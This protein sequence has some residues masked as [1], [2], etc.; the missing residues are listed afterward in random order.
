MPAHHRQ[1]AGNVPGSAPRPSR[2]PFAFLGRIILFLVGI[3]ILFLAVL[4]P[5]KARL[6]LS[7]AIGRTMN[8]FYHAYIR[9]FRWFLRK[10]EED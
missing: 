5:Y 3:L 9:L 2:H 4:L 10:L 8:A 7:D 1:T 6:W